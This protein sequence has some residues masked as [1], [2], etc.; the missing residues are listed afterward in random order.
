M[1]NKLLEQLSAARSVAVGGHVRPDGDC[2]GSCMGVYHY[3]K[4]NYPQTQVTVYLEEVPESYKI[5]RDTDRIVTDDSAEVYPD[6]FI[7]VDCSDKER[8]GKFA[9]YF[10]HA[11]KT[12]CIDHHISNPGYADENII[13]PQ[14]SSTCEVLCDLFDDDKVGLDAANALYMGIICDTGCFKH[15]STS[16]HTMLAAGRLISKGVHTENIMDRVFFEKT[17]VQNR[18]LG[19]CLMDSL[20]YMEGKVI[21]GIVTREIFDEFH[22]VYSDLE[23]VIDQLRQTRGTLAAILLSENADGSWKLSMR[24]K[25]GVNVADIAASYGGGGHIKAAGAT[26]Y[27][28][29]QTVINEIIEKI[30]AQLKDND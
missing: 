15:T 9:A 10:D 28:Q 3:I 29:P 8:L 22:A 21:V 17:Y 1:N 20:L 5:I 11:A 2:V 14:A 30:G 25:D 24:S 6:L 16:E 26:V 19:R 18:L 23:G 7:A 27:K 12:I 4:D 13:C